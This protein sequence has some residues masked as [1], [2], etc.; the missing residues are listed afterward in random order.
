MLPGQN[1]AGNRRRC[2]SRQSVLQSMATHEREASTKI[3]VFLTWPPMHFYLPPPSIAGR[4]GR[5]VHHYNAI[6][7][8]SIQFHSTLHPF[9]P[10]LGMQAL[11]P[12]P[13]LAM[14]ALQPHPLL[15]MIAIQ[16]QHNIPKALRIHR[17]NHPYK[18][19][20]TWYL[21]KLCGQCAVLAPI[22]LRL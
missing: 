13:L 17:D 6:Q 7:F 10:H 3:D 14:L 22:Q 8:N 9:V 5:A 19:K 11:Q 4:E 1:V 15:A 2:H 18:T 21:E 12:H 16:P 20:P